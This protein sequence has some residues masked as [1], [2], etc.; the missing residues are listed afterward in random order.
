MRELKRYRSCDGLEFNSISECAAHEC[1]VAIP[2]RLS[3]LMFKLYA[4]EF[5]AVTD[6]ATR[7][8]I[9]NVVKVLLLNRNNPRVVMSHLKQFSDQS[10]YLPLEPLF[11]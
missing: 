8:T 6:A 3:S 1:N 7:T 4:A 2:D 5:G 9:D 10:M 11:A